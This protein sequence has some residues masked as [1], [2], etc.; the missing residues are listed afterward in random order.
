MFAA[1]KYNLANLTN[2]SGRDARPTFWLYV[3]FLVIAQYVVGLVISL[4]LMGGMMQGVMDGVKNGMSEAELQAQMLARM[5]GP[6]RS[7]MIFSMGL[8]L[9]SSALLV[10]S[11]VRRL[12]DSN[13]PGWIA[14]IAFLFVLGAQAAS[15]ANMD[16]LIDAMSISATASGSPEAILAAQGPLIYASM[17]S[18]L[19]M[20]I[21]IVFGVW[22]STDGPNRYG[23]EPVG[24]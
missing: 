13:R 10:A 16:R 8:Y 22:P 11:F 4:P 24:D 23:E 14:A 18:W 17:L 12:H 2:F 3:L 15:M 9:V 20:L 1:I 19:G 6:M 7:A 21:V 5:T